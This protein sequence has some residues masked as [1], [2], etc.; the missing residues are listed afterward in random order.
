M[1]SEMQ[2][3]YEPLTGSCSHTIIKFLPIL[4]DP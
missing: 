2:M 4:A 3:P 1:Q